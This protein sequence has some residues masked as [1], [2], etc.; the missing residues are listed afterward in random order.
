MVYKIVFSIIFGLL[1]LFFGTI[2]FYVAP[3]FPLVIFPVALTLLFLVA[4][5]AVWDDFKSLG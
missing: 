1:A 3:Y 4:I 2:S 5:Y